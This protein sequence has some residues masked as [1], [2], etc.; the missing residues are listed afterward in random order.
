M[1]STRFKA[2]AVPGLTYDKGLSE[3]VDYLKDE[4]PRDLYLQGMVQ[5]VLVEGVEL[6]IR[7]L[8]CQQRV[9]AALEEKLACLERLIPFM[10]VIT[11]KSDDSPATTSQAPPAKKQKPTVPGETASVIT[12]PSRYQEPAWLW[13]PQPY[14]YQPSVD[15]PEDEPTTPLQQ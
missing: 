7:A 4:R 1:D 14:P 9:R 10:D 15:S 2:A 5:E 3:L 11:A 13:T 8:I 12:P 6:P